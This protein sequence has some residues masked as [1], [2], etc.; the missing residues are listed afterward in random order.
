MITVFL[1]CSFKDPTALDAETDDEQDK[2]DHQFDDRGIELEK[3]VQLRGTPRGE[4]HLADAQYRVPPQMTADVAATFEYLLFVDGEIEQCRQHTRE[5]RR[6]DDG[7]CG[8]G[9]RLANDG[10]KQRVEQNVHHER[11]HRR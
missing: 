11:G 4:C 10:Q 8:D 3:R 1:F 2:V 6:N 9:G 7:L 5:H